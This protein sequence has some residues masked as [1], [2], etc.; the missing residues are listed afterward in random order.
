MTDI[1]K[2]LVRL[3]ELSKWARE[4]GSRIGSKT[5]YS[6]SHLSGTALNDEDGRSVFRLD[7]QSSRSLS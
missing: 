1:S 4:A 6:T 7:Y 5:A 3:L 2:A